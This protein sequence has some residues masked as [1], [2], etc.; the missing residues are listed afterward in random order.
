M[1]AAK[2]G[3]LADGVSLAD[4]GPVLR[5]S[6]PVVLCQR[7]E[8]RQQLQ[9]APGESGLGRL[10]G[11]VVHAGEFR[12]GNPLCAGE[13]DLLF[14][15]PQVLHLAQQHLAEV[16]VADIVLGGAEVVHERCTLE[17]SASALH[18]AVEVDDKRRSATD[19]RKEPSRFL[20]NAA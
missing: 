4:L 19:V 6:G 13:Y 5:Q 10:D 3:T 9:A 12:S 14:P 17:K 18:V 16:L 15:S 20:S 7:H 8:Q 2:A 1:S 11:N